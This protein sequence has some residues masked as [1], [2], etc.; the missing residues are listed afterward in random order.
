LRFCTAGVALAL[1]SGSALAADHEVIGAGGGGAVASSWRGDVAAYAPLQLGYRY[2]RVVSL[3]ALV[4]VGYATV[5]Q[6]MLT[7]LSI[8]PTLWGRLGPTQ[9]Y[10]RL[11]L[12]HQH[13]ESRAA[14]ADDPGGAAL[15]VGNGIRH[16]GGFAASVG[17][18]LPFQKVRKLGEWFV[19]VDASATYFPDDRGPAIYA[20]GTVWLGF[21]L[22]LKG[23]S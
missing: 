14:I 7:Y 22:D 2:K 19:G 16:R 11:A 5:D 17:L 3:D 8:G 23:G 15:G 4:R 21:A 20:G 10:L 6:R 9:P 1:V 18:D 13:E 12:V